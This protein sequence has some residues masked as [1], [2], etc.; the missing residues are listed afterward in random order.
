[1]L[2]EECGLLRPPCRSRLLVEDTEANRALAQKY[3]IDSVLETVP[4]ITPVQAA[5]LFGG[6][7]D[8]SVLSPIDLLMIRGFNMMGEGDFRNFDKIAQWSK[9]LYTVIK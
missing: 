4:Q 8:F 3:Y 7:M 1:L 2:F 9:D 6:I 5:G